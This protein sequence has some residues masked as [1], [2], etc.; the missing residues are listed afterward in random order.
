MAYMGMGRRPAAA[1]AA[2][3]IV[4]RPDPTGGDG[5]DE[6]ERAL[7]A[8][9]VKRLGKANGREVYRI[10]TPE[11]E[12]VR[13]TIQARGGFTAG[14]PAEKMAASRP[15]SAAG[16][17]MSGGGSYRPEPGPGSAGSRAEFEARVNARMAGQPRPGSPGPGIAGSREEFE[18][19]INARMAG[20]RAGGYVPERDADGL[21]DRV[22][23]PE[24]GMDE[25]LRGMGSIARRQEAGKPDA[26]LQDALGAIPLTGYGPGASAYGSDAASAGPE[27]S[28]GLAGGYSGGDAAASALRGAYLGL[29]DQY[30]RHLAA[31]PEMPDPGAFPGP[32][33]R[34]LAQAATLGRL[35]ERGSYSFAPAGL[36]EHWQM[37]Q[38]SGRLNRTFNVGVDTRTR[39]QLAR[40]ASGRE[41]VGGF[42]DPAIADRF[43]P[44][45]ERIRQAEAAPVL[46]RAEGLERFR[47]EGEGLRAVLAGLERAARMP[48]GDPASAG[49]RAPRSLEEWVLQDAM[50]R[51]MSP[52]Q[53]L[54]ERAEATRAPEKAAVRTPYQALEDRVASG[55]ATADEQARYFKMRNPDGGGGGGESREERRRREA[56]AIRGALARG[57]DLDGN[58]LGEQE[59]AELVAEYDA[60]MGPGAWEEAEARAA[61]REERSIED[62]DRETS[63]SM[64]GAG[65]LA[66]ILRELGEAGAA[67]RAQFPRPSDESETEAG[68]IEAALDQ[69]EESGELA[70]F[71]KEY[72][73]T[74]RAMGEVVERDAQGR[75]IYRELGPDTV[76]DFLRQRLRVEQAEGQRG[77]RPQDFGMN[78]GTTPERLEAEQIDRD[79]YPWLGGLNAWVARNIGT[80]RTPFG[81]SKDEGL[82]SR[83][84][85][86]GRLR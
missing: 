61:T 74:V 8:G 82:L 7:A 81:D 84:H 21:G 9:H 38:G 67:A 25:F 73:P 66:K 71:V 36:G 22:D 34:D 2:P 69:L 72:G 18:A 20:G 39:S 77:E 51:G 52:T 46:A 75:P 14:R 85:G 79:M 13:A 19:R 27:A 12:R 5:V 53:A 68:A 26:A 43:A 62:A 3:G 48:G 42:V 41:R 33:P 49:E 80:Q 47:R 4:R 65:R 60:R 32:D 11:G 15:E 57:A 54:R 10:L 37:D 78:V 59:R 17:Y 35:A 58:P 28:A 30:G 29:V 6:V 76:R 64:A 83:L 86:Y 55:Q 24:M 44:A 1:A 23:P 63:R 50:K 31:G 56:V 16:G 40:A 45:L 70:E